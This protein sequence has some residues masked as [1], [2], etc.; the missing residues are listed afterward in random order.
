[1]LNYGVTF[2]LSFAKLFSN[3][4]FENISIIAKI[5]KLLITDYCT[6]CT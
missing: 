6:Y 3:A 5:N 4:I 1:M 2:N